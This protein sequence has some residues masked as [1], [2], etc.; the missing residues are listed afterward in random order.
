MMKSISDTRNPTNYHHMNF[1]QSAF[2]LIQI[3]L[4]T[5]NLHHKT[6]MF[7]K[8]KKEGNHNSWNRNLEH[9]LQGNLNKKVSLQQLEV[10]TLL[11]IKTV[12]PPLCL[13]TFRP[14]PGSKDLVKE[15][16][17]R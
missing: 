7:Q 8:H 17:A 5:S 10:G 14:P 11:E 6:N 2:F 3:K 12:T 13:G 15:D 4:H 16:E 1:D 9:K